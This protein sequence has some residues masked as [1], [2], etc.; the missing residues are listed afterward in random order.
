MSEYKSFK[1]K[2]FYYETDGMRIVHH[3]N[4]IRYFEEARIYWLENIGYSYGRMEEE[5]IMIPVLK[6]SAEYKYPIRFNDEF[7]IKMTITKFNGNRFKV[8]YIINNLAQGKVSA[9]GETE[10][11]FVNFNMRPIRVKKEHIEIYNVFSQNVGREF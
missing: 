3:S 2:A 8:K 7:E 1:R 5:G 11:C 10:H 9:Y 4:Y 6:A